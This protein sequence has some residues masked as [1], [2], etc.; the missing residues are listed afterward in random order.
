MLHGHF[1][2]AEKVVHRI[3]QANKLDF[4]QEAFEKAKDQS[5]IALN[6]VKTSSTVSI[7]DI[8][9]APSLQKL[10]MILTMAL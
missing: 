1:E 10:S 4:P 6:G 8:Y 2:K 3:T 7:F 5:Q 9:R